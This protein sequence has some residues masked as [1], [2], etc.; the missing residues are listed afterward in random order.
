MKKIYT[1]IILLIALTTVLK[2]QVSEQ[3]FQALKALYNSTNGDQW[4]N[5]T[6]WENINTTATKDDVT[7]SWFGIGW[8][9]SGHITEIALRT[10]NITGQLPPEIGNLVWLKD[11]S[12]YDN[13][14]S[15]TLPNELGNLI[16]L[17]AF[18]LND[19]NIIGP[20]PLT[21]INLT[22]IHTVY[23]STNPLNCAFPSEIISHWPLLKHFQA[24]SCGLTGQLPEIFNNFPALEYLILNENNLE[25]AIPSSLGNCPLLYALELYNNEI[26]GNL[27]AL[28]NCLNLNTITLNDND[29]SGPIPSS[30][31]NF[32]KLKYFRISNNNITGVIPNGIFT[33]LRGIDV[34]NN[35]FSFEALEPVSA[36]IASFG[37]WKFSTNKNFPLNTNSQ[38]INKGE[39]LTLNATALSIYNLGGNNNRY[40]WYKDDVEVYSGNS[41]AYSVASASTS[42]AGIYRFEVTNTVV[43]DITLKSDNITVSVVGSNQPPT[44]ISLSSS[45]VNENFTGLFGTISATDSDASDTHTF[46]L[47]TGNGTNDKDNNKFSISGNQLTLNN[48]ANFETTP[49]LNI[50]V[51][52]N[53]GN[54]GIFTK[55][56]VITVNDVNE[57]PVYNGQLTSNTIDENAANGSTALSLMAFDPEGS[58]VTFSIIQG[59]D[60]GAFGINGDKLVV[61][62]HTKFNYDTKNSYSLI[63]N[64]SDGTLSSNATLII[65]LNKINSMP[66]VEDAVFSIDENSPNGTVV[67]SIVASDR[68]G[69]PLTYSIVSGNGSSAITLTG[70]IIKVANS[71]PLDY[72]TTP[73]FVLTVNVS[74][75]ISNVQA[76]VTINLNDVAENTDNAITTFT[77]PGMEGEA[78]IDET[79]HTIRA[80]VRDVDL[81]ALVATFTLSAEATSTPVSGT[82]LNFTT[83]QTITVSAQSGNVQEWV[84]TVNLLVGKHEM[85]SFNVKIYPNPVSN[86]LHISGIS[87]SAVLKIVSLTGQ[88]LLSG[89]VNHENELFDLSFLNRGNYFI[90]IDSNNVRKTLNFYKR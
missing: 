18:N 2:A 8:I 66:V 13:K 61:A 29:L 43:A 48:P 38:T 49:T 65:N 33:V 67:G 62:D 51:S 44:N 25:G 9:E 84:V 11:L 35:F 7:T 37:T 23:I 34:Y 57:A 82:T 70:N 59:N 76:T 17:E 31:N 80:S 36:R 21:I 87:K 50:L 74:D 60:D 89:K 24:S 14:I 72:E 79:T 64:A 40:K 81:S 4:T 42:D 6:G 27:P 10:N 41:P 1:L 58:P 63:V 54:G 53:D 85:E 28:E 68:E 56:I 77:L 5:R 71:T 39:S 3:E 90:I 78:I 22:K 26:S 46:T 19:N 55:E 47:A 45:S 69:D 75:G 20:L 30:F 12:M 88:T 73:Q 83:P 16:N 15:G 52:V 32:I 86:F